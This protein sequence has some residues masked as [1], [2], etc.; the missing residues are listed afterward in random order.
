M[1]NCDPG[2]LE[3]RHQE[4]LSVV[5]SG[6]LWQDEHLIIARLGTTADDKEDDN[7]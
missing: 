3:H 6:K 1:D 4:H 7:G 5:D 2:V